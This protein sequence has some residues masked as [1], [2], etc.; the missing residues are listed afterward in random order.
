MAVH[1]NSLCVAYCDFLYYHRIYC[2]SFAGFYSFTQKT[3]TMKKEW[4][5]EFLH[6]MEELSLEE[7]AAINGGESLWYWIG[8]GLGRAANYISNLD[9]QQTSGQKA[10][11]AALG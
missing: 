11:N 8:Y 10:M 4:K 9:G 3:R 7:S 6:G 5:G 2:Q 1:G